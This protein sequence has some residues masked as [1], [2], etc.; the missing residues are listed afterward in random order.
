MGL[1]GAG[2]V[3]GWHHIEFEVT[4]KIGFSPAAVVTANGHDRYGWRQLDHFLNWGQL[5]K[6][7]LLSQLKTRLNRAKGNRFSSRDFPLA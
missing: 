2:I 1:A 3:F 5:V 6:E 4:G 7:L